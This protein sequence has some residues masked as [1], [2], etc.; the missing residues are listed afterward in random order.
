MDIVTFN[1]T[2]RNETFCL[3]RH[4]EIIFLAEKRKS[5]FLVCFFGASS[6]VTSPFNAHKPAINKTFILKN[7]SNDHVL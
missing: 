3:K 5:V 2:E 4:V 7:G 6:L 1:T